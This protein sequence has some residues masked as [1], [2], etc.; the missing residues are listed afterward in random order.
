[1]NN[2]LQFFIINLK[3]FNKYFKIPLSK[4]YNNKE[5]KNFK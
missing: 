5:I 4:F 1:M 3:K 2:L